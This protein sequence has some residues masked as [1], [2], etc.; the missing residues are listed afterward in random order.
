MMSMDARIITAGG[1]T[2]CLIGS[3]CSILST[4]FRDRSVGVQAPDGRAYEGRSVRKMDREFGEVL[5]ARNG[6]SDRH[7]VRVQTVFSVADLKTDS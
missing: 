5:S 3:R 7:P 6:L 2:V 1:R 4:A